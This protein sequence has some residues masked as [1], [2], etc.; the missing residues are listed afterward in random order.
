[1]PF[2]IMPDGK[3]A[4]RIGIYSLSKQISHDYRKISL[5]I[6]ERHHTSYVTPKAFYYSCY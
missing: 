2:T 3:S 4:T 6:G 1:M 5:T